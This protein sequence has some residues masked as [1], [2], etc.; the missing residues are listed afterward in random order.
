MNITYVNVSSLKSY[1]NNAKKHPDSQVE[2]VAK[3]IKE[4]GFRQPVVIDENNQIIIG[5]CRFLAAKKLKL[6]QIPAVYA[7]D[8][9]EDQIKALRLVDNKLNESEWDYKLFNAE[10]KDITSIDM[11]QFSRFNIYVSD[12]YFD[13][14]LFEDEDDGKT[15][16]KVK[17]I[18]CPCCGKDFEV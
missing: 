3:S 8:L 4:F 5:H 17:T 11:S 10:I 14:E 16:A 18:T 2:A 7:D 9:S 12:E 1:K 13:P 6:K 15:E